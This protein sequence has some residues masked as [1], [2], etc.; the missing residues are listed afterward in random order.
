MTTALALTDDGA[1]VA[2]QPSRFFSSRA[3]FQKNRVPSHPT[4]FTPI[5]LEEANHSV[6]AVLGNSSPR[7]KVEERAKKLLAEIQ[8]EVETARSS[9]NVELSFSMTDAEKVAE[10]R[11]KVNA[12]SA[13]ALLA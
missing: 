13:S 8:N 10:L 9:L 6:H 12:A 3:S 4:S 7:K 1:N 11:S 5:P 2:E